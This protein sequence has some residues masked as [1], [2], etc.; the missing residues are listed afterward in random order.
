MVDVASFAAS[1]ST[2]VIL[3]GTQS[4]NQYTFA[5]A[6]VKSCFYLLFIFGTVIFLTSID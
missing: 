4:L 5:Q 1:Q 6:K 2:G 3:Y